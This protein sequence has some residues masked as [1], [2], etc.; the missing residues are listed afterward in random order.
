MAKIAFLRAYIVL[1]IFCVVTTAANAGEMYITPAAVYTDDDKDRGA[2]DSVAGGQFSLGWVLSNRVSLEAMAGHSNLNGGDDLRITEGSLNLLY[3]LRPNSNFSPYFLGGV[4][5]MHS[6]SDV[7][8][9][10]NSTLGNLGVGLKLRFG[11]SPVSLR[12]EYRA[13]F[14][15]ANTL[16][17]DDRITSL[18]LQFAFG[19]QESS[20]PVPA[21][22]QDGD[23][24][25]DGVPDGRD[26]CP[27][28]PAGQGVD[29]RGCPLDSDGDGVI[30]DQDP[31]P[32]TFRG[33]AVDSWGCERDDDR[34]GIVNRLD[35]C[36]NTS[37][38]VPVDI[39]GCEIREVIELPGVNFETNSDRLLPGTESVLH[40]AAATLR[41]NPDLIVEVAGHTDSAGSETHNASLSERRAITVRDFLVALGA[42]SNNLTAR[43]YGEGQ[44]IADN[45][46]AA[47]RARNR[48]VELRV[49]HR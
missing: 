12:L 40:D 31:C 2:D 39:K 10:E 33:A 25:G 11:D 41:R 42:G 26:A 22:L 17:Y 21:V 48:R 43:G 38:G 44:P 15:T 47:G 29:S 28:T 46:T 34:D 45:A 36:P 27:N 16:S 9:P 24:D 18:G 23:A 6:D 8:D 30:D 7:Q 37:P 13:R 35:N 5:L 19:G 49:Q 4:G 32:D 1:G 3:S 14:E 20:V